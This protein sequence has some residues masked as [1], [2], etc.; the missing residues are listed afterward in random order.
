MTVPVR[1]RL[2]STPQRLLPRLV[3][4]IFGI[5]IPQIL[6]PIVIVIAVI[7]RRPAAPPLMPLLILLLLLL[8]GLGL[9]RSEC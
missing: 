8:L 4:P 1:Q 5:A 7:G 3:L 9:E 2:G 6:L